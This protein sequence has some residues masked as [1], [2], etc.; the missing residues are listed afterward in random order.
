MAT[1]STDLSSAIPRNPADWEDDGNL[2]LKYENLELKLE[3]QKLKY[4]KEQRTLRENNG[5]RTNEIKSDE[6]TKREQQIIEEIKGN[7]KDYAEL[8]GGSE[9][10]EDEIEKQNKQE[11]LEKEIP[12]ELRKRTL[13]RHEINDAAILEERRKESEKLSEEEQRILE[14]INKFL[15]R[16]RAATKFFTTCEDWV[17]W[18][19]DNTETNEIV[20]MEFKNRIFVKLYSGTKHTIYLTEI[21]DFPIRDNSETVIPVLRKGWTRLNTKCYLLKDAEGSLQDM[22]SLLTKEIRE[23]EIGKSFSIQIKDNTCYKLDF[24]CILIFEKVDT[25][26]K[27]LNALHESVDGRSVYTFFFFFFFLIF[28]SI[29]YFV[30]FR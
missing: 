13:Q 25:D 28:I 30:L 5:V 19:L 11:R 23:Q 3:V 8:V 2:K 9:A 7:K 20:K 18:F 22:T 26:N 4:E 10:N 16:K 29:Y 1:E 12:M 27:V 6:E 15:L 21:E 14:G 17:N 24:F